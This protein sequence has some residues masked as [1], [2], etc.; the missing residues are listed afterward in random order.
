[1]TEKRD[2]LPLCD[3]LFAII[4][5]TL[6]FC[7]IVFDIALAYALYLRGNRLYCSI[8]FCVITFSLV[9]C[10]I[11]SIRWYIKSHKSPDNLCENE[12]SQEISTTTVAGDCERRRR[13]KSYRFVIICHLLCAGVFFRF[14][15][16]F[17][18]VDLKTVKNE[19]RDLSIIRVVQAFSEAVPMLILQ[20][21]LYI[22]IQNEAAYNK[23][24]TI[25]GEILPND[26]PTSRHQ[27]KAF[28]DLNVV[29]AALSLCSICWAL[30]SFNKHVRLSSV[31]QLVLTWAG[32][33]VQVSWVQLSR[34][35]KI[36]CCLVQK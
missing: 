3:L 1:M 17:V 21:N 16:L 7:A 10:Q 20:L 8:A 35:P 32:V 23:L 24:E 28:R 2:L 12:K 31:R 25:G 11:I 9:I 30:A 18:P 27:E 33:I 29:S 5:L 15:R 6:L 19:F 36:F 34:E 13:K 22:S 26:L 4:S 14:A